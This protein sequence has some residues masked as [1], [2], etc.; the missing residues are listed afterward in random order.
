MPI[1][2]PEARHLDCEC[3][4]NKK[5]Y[6][7]GDYVMK[8]KRKP[9][10]GRKP[11]GPFANS[12][13]QLTIRMPEDLRGQLARSAKK[14]G[15]SL[16]QELLWRLDSSYKKQRDREW[17]TP[18]TRALGFLVR[19]VMQR[20]EFWELNGWHRN[21]FLFRAFRLAV[22]KLLEALEPPGDVSGPYEQ[23]LE[24]D[25][26]SRF[27]TEETRASYM[28]PEAHADFVVKGLL[29]ALLRPDPRMETA[30]R[31]LR[32]HPTHGRVAEALLDGFYGF[33]D[34][35]RDMGINR[36]VIGGGKL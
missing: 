29:E 9:G 2:I 6:A 5:A 15:W 23:G 8:R 18:V 12:S 22:G 11:A 31:E 24:F 16:T 26:H 25:A 17:A 27:S 13:T 20:I 10:A 32:G 35:C 30:L 28:T 33:A 21:P 3:L 36:R 7:E 14:K 19:E 34:V 1:D 4:A